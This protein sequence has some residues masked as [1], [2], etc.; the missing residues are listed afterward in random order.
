MQRLLG[1][2]ALYDELPKYLIMENV[3]PL[4]GK[5][6]LLKFEEWLNW[7]SDCGYKSY[8]QVLNAA[9][10]GIPQKREGYLRI[11]TQRPYESVLFPRKTTT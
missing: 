10:Y 11:Y 2:A 4:V 1:R 3:K 6:F 9:D 5:K 8:W 7:L